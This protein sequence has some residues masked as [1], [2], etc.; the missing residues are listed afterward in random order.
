MRN[1]FQQSLYEIQMIKHEM[2]SGFRLQNNL[3]VSNQNNLNST[4]VPTNSQ[5]TPQETVYNTNSNTQINIKI[6]DGREIL[7]KTPENMTKSYGSFYKQVYSNSPT[8]LP[9]EAPKQQ[10]IDWYSIKLPNQGRPSQKDSPF[11]I[12]YDTNH[13]K[14]LF[15][16]ESVQTEKMVGGSDYLFKNILERNYSKMMEK[17]K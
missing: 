2:R 9:F 5:Q 14:E 11:S 8:N 12:N 3:V 10:E 7:T 17:K 16:D 13:L 1:E 4:Q 6:P 15:Q